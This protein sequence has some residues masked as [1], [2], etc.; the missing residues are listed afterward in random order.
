M[1]ENKSIKRMKLSAG[2]TEFKYKKGKYYLQDRGCF[3][4]N[5]KVYALYFEGIPNPISFDNI[6]K[7]KK[8][9]DDASLTIDSSVIK[10]MTEK[11]FLSALTATTISALDTLYLMILIIS[12]GMSA[13]TLFFVYQL[14]QVV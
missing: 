10:D 2:K 8:E 3:L 5:K 6:N 1:R 14:Y 4:R 13:V 12:I 9:G 7:P 11:D